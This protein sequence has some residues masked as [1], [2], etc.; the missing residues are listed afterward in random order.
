MKMTAT[1]NGKLPNPSIDP[2][3]LKI[4]EDNTPVTNFQLTDCDESGQAAIVFCVDVSTSILSSAGDTWTISQAYFNSFAKFIGYIP[5]ASRYALATF[6]D[7]VSYYPGPNHPGGFYS[8]QNAADSTDFIFNLKDQSFKG[9]TDVDNA[10]NVSAG[11]LQYQPFKQKAI[12]LVTDDAIIDSPFFDSLLNTLGITLYVM[13]IGYDGAPVNQLV[14]HPTGGVYLHAPD[15]SQHVS[16]MQ[17]LAELVFGDHCVIRYPSTNP[18][19][20]V[21]TH[22]ISLTLNYKGLSDN[23]LE[24]YILGRNIF[25]T[26]PPTFTDISPSYTTRIV[27]VAENYPCTRGIR[28]FS[29][30]AL[31][32]FTILSQIRN[33]PNLCSDNLTPID[34][35]QPASAVYIAIDSGFNTGREIVKYSPK[36]DT[37]APEIAGGQSPGGIYNMVLTEVRGWDMG[38]K[39]VYMQPGA[40]NLVLDSFIIISRRVGEAW[41]HKPDPTAA[42]SG[43]LDVVDSAGNIATYCVRSDSLTGDTLPPVITQNPIVS[44]RVRITGSVTEEQFKD[45]GIKNITILPAVNAGASTITFQSTRHATFSLP[46]IDSLQPI[47]APITASDS[48]GNSSYDTL[49]YDP[50]PDL[51]APVC[52]IESPDGKTRIFHSTELAPWDRGIASVKIIGTPTN[53]NV[54][55]VVYNTPYQVSQ[56]F[57]I[58]DQFVPAYAVIIATDSVGQ[59]CETT[60]EID[61][62]PRPLIPFSATNLIDF[63]TVYAPTSQSKTF[64]IT[65]PNPSPVIVTKIAQ[66]GDVPIFSSDLSNPYIFQPNETKIFTVFFN[67]P[68]LGSWRSDWTISND[69]MNLAAFEAIGHTI[70]QVNIGLDTVNVLNTQTQGKLTISISAI[71]A[72]INLDTLSFTIVYDSDMLN[73]LPS[74]GSINNY[75]I[76]STPI[77]NSKVNYQLLRQDRSLPTTLAFPLSS[78]DI[79][80]TCNVAKHD[81]AILM[82]QDI[83]I[84]QQSTASYSPGMITVGSQCGDQTLRNFLNGRLPLVATAVVPNPANK[85]VTITIL[86]QGKHDCEISLVNPLGEITIRKNISLEQGEQSKT[87]DLST[88][89]AGNYQV[90]LTNQ[91]VIISVQNLS[92]VR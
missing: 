53:L 29:D 34:T 14:T 3:N 21:K 69:T 31:K 57:T 22:D 63:G 66:K 90:I 8:G 75:S 42:T 71:P 45:V 64:Q 12:V 6:T 30:S 37:L 62:V 5:A 77:S 32:N 36:P 25:D 89:P 60:I 13:E 87:L 84:G 52:S 59:F 78:F 56:T 61:S 91:N 17:L 67:A 2:S 83:F 47:R 82:L 88:V 79:P 46:V 65:N 24:Q 85:L 39:N 20:W 48:V 7:Q 4:T 18:C 68:L 40:Q 10:V 76:N 72:P 73:L 80:F 86:S 27:K 38:L 55:P 28:S 33:Y 41:M 54:G 43:C 26:D 70:G 92:V 19:P 15:T 44:P 50:E 1:Y 35:M 9:F 74:T 23:T 58:I 11:L 49:R 51:T 16:T 81:T